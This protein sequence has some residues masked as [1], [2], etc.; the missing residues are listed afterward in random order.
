MKLTKT[1]LRKII[2]EELENLNMNKEGVLQE[3]VLEAGGVKATIAE[4][5]VYFESARGNTVVP[6]ELAI[7]VVEHAT[8]V[9]LPKKGGFEPVEES[10]GD[11]Q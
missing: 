4:D 1:K 3:R 8:G 11:T 5:Y 7:S 9:M 10:K 2:Q 6:L